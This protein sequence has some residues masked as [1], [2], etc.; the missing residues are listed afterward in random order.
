HLHPVRT[1][2]GAIVTD[3]FPPDHA[4]QSGIFFAYTKTKFEDRDVDFWNLAGGKGRVRFK[5]LK[6][7]SSGPVFGEIQA[8]HEH[9]DLSAENAN[10]KSPDDGITGGKVA[11]IEDWDVRIWTA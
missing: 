8:L 9:V 10:K 5:E 3:Q 2:S 11:L 7:I 4:H 1:P 6:G